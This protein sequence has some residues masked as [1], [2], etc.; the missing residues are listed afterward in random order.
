MFKDVWSI[1][2]DMEVPLCIYINMLLRCQELYYS[3]V[4]RS[5]NALI[6][7]GKNNSTVKG[8]D[9]CTYLWQGWW[10]QTSNYWG[11]L[12]LA[13][14]YKIPSNICFLMLTQYVGEINGDS[15]CLFSH[16]IWITKLLYVQR[17]SDI[18]EKNRNAMDST[19]P[20]YRL[21]QHPCF[22]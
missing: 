22:S 5:E 2:D 6:L 16:N 7:F 17:L 14:T 11:V 12:V 15:Q 9:D 8:V 10:K 20:I 4:L 18:L 3:S 21:Q 13:T 1:E 19:S